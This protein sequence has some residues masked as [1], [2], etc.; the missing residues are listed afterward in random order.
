MSRALDRARQHGGLEDDVCGKG[1]GEGVLGL[2]GEGACPL[3]APVALARVGLEEPIHV[4]GDL[5]GLLDV[6]PVPGVLDRLGRH[7]RESRHDRLRDE[8]VGHERIA[9]AA[10]HQHRSR[11]AAVLPASRMAGVPG[12]PEVPDDLGAKPGSRGHQPVQVLVCEGDGELSASLALRLGSLL[13]E[14]AERLNLLGGK[15][16]ASERH[17]CE[18]HQP[19]GALRT[20]RDKL[21]DRSA[22]AVADNDERL[23]DS[24][25]DI[26]H[27]GRKPVIGERAGHVDAVAT[28]VQ[29]DLHGLD[30]AGE[31]V[32]D[33]GP[34]VSVVEKAVNEDHDVV[35]VPLW[36]QFAVGAGHEGGSCSSRR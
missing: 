8:L 22:H 35:T 33:T 23:A 6:G 10:Q 1:L 31:T 18:Q 15:V 29:V 34:G 9:A 21:G 13:A 3:D 32:D 36:L 12:V 24:V 19:E 4:G 26:P 20:A 7:G 30:V 28:A 14:R 17:R 11:V 27:R 5:P 16:G 25:N 2:L